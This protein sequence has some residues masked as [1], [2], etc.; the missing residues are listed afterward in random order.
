MLFVCVEWHMRCCQSHSQN[1]SAVAYTNRHFLR[2]YNVQHNHFFV[3]FFILHSSLYSGFCVRIWTW[4]Y[5]CCVVYVQNKVKLLAICPPGEFSIR[6]IKCV[7]Y[8]LRFFSSRL[9]SIINCWLCATYN[10]YGFLH[11]ILSHI[12]LYK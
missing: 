1:L 6:Y 4:L 10:S 12:C 8:V 5:P 7:A 3:F 9:L 11:N 2:K